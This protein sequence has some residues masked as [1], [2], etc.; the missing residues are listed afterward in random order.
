M[1]QA[2]DHQLLIE[3]E[4]RRKAEQQLRQAE[5]ESEA[6]RIRMEAERAEAKRILI[7]EA[8]SPEVQGVLHIFLLPRY[9]QPKPTGGAMGFRHGSGAPAHVTVHHRI[10][11]SIAA[12]D[13]RLKDAGQDRY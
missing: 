2:H 13:R 4:T 5:I 8:H 1:E 7:E 12:R 6:E 11:G 9:L 10:D 3:L